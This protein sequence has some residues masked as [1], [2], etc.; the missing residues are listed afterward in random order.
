MLHA[1]WHRPR[2]KLVL[3]PTSIGYGYATPVSACYFGFA[4][5]HNELLSVCQQFNTIYSY[6]VCRRS[7][8]PVL[9]VV[10]SS[11]TVVPSMPI[12]QLHMAST[13]FAL[14]ARCVTGRSP[15]RTSCTNTSRQSMRWSGR[16]TV[17]SKI[18][19]QRLFHFPCLVLPSS[20]QNQ[21]FLHPLFLLH[22]EPFHNRTLKWGF[23]GHPLRVQ[24]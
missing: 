15:G 23:S 8:W 24:R 3:M 9:S 20:C 12:C 10:D 21:D 7:P 5:R 14:V 18:H 6:W 19:E 2:E 1:W 22:Q 16:D 11:T 17:P 13:T 4:G